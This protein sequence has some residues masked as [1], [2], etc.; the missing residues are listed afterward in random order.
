MKKI[1]LLLFL[2]NFFS[3]FSQSF[4]IEKFSFPLPKSYKHASSYQ[5]LREEISIEEIGA[6]TSGLW[7]NG[8]DYPCPEKTPVYATKAGVVKCV[9]PGYYNGEKFKGH[10]TYGGLIII[11]HFDGTISL[12]A[13]LSCTYVKEG[14]FVLKDSNIGLSGGVKGKRASGLSTGP[15]LHYSVYID[16]NRILEK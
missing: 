1:I 11:N 14:D 15:H 6:S 16:I 3:L 5:N 12:Y 7:H 4:I 8:I 9:Y 2:I 13:H 10:P